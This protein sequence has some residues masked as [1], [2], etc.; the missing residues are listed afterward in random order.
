M[1][2]QKIVDYILDSVDPE[3]H[4]KHVSRAVAGAL[5]DLDMFGTLFSSADLDS[6]TQCAR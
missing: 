4:G 3:K 5:N 2:A 1:D 6:Q